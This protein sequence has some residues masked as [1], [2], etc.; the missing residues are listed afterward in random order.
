MLAASAAIATDEGNH[1][2]FGHEVPAWL[3]GRDLGVKLSLAKDEAEADSEDTAQEDKVVKVKEQDVKHKETFAA[4]SAFLVATEKGDAIE[5][6]KWRLGTT[7]VI[8]VKFER[9]PGWTQGSGKMFYH[10][11]NSA[12]HTTVDFDMINPFDVAEVKAT[13]L[14]ELPGGGLSVKGEVA[15]LPWTR[16]RST[17]S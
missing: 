8:L 11:V 17:P 16:L 6:R 1:V 5:T 2:D 10:H 15:R 12:A 9:A 13:S 3:I 4:K 7:Q 14:A